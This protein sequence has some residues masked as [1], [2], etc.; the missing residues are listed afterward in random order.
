MNNF[1][2]IAQIISFTKIFE[3]CILNRVSKFFEKS[4]ILSPYQFGY[5][6]GFTVQQSIVKFL[7]FCAENQT[8]N[9]YFSSIFLDCTK[10][11][12]S[13]DRRILFIKLERYGIRGN[14]LK[15]FKSYLSDRTVLVEVN[16][17]ISTS[18][19]TSDYGVLQGSSLSALLFIIYV[20]DM[21]MSVP[22]ST[23][24]QYADDAAICCSSATLRELQDQININLNH[25][26]EWFDANLISL[27][28]QKT[29]YLT[30]NKDEAS[31]THISSYLDGRKQFWKIDASN[32]PNRYLGFWIDNKLNVKTFFDKVIQKMQFG[33]F[34]LSRIRNFYPEKIKI[35]IFNCF[36]QSHLEFCAVFY[37]LGSLKIRHKLFSVQKR[38]LKLV[39]STKEK[40][41]Y[42]KLFV[43]YDVLPIE[44]LCKLRIFQLMH[45]LVQSNR[46]SQFCNEWTFRRDLY[47]GLNLRNAH[48]MNIPFTYKQKIKTMP[49]VTFPEVY[50]EL[51]DIFQ[52]EDIK[53]KFN[54]LRSKLLKN[55]DDKSCMKSKCKICYRLNTDIELAEL[56]R[57]EKRERRDNLIAIKGLRKKERYAKILKKLKIIESK[58][59]KILNA[60]K[61][62]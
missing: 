61:T 34:I 7:N 51:I 38:G 50:N 31:T 46:L 23:C 36:V 47:K 20:N 19:F 11:F 55:Y 3:K 41:H 2:P 22:N 35:Q 9:R 17:A 28:L 60:K 54:L 26:T 32:D 4:N 8:H 12:D 21:N 27:N 48:H 25:L 33:V 56:A 43:L 37:H 39:K 13:I 29:E 24:L 45:M 15:W 6:H 5:R 44:M 10:A 14:M 49:Y 53:M 16:N 18:T 58:K 59:D 62:S 57:R 42:K 1:R 52:S 30:F 40:L